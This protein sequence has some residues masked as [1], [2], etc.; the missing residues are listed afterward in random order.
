MKF[1]TTILIC[2]VYL[3]VIAQQ[4]AQFTQYN[5]VMLTVNPAYAG[6]RDMLNVTALHRQQWVGL[7]GAPIT[8]SV[9]LHTPLKYESLGIGLSVLNDRVGALNQSMISGDFSYSIRLDDSKNLRSSDGPRLSF[10]IKGSL[11]MLNAD[12]MALY[13]PDPNDVAF[14]QNYSNTIS[15]NVGM[16]VYF[17]SKQFFAGFSVPTIITPKYDPT[18]M[19]YARQRH[20]Y[21]TVGGYFIPNRMLKIRP[22]M[23]LKFTE[24][25]PLAID[26]SLA[27]IFYDKFWIAAN[28]R[29]Q[30]SAGVYAQYQLNKNFKVG[31]GFDIS[32]NALIKHNFGTHEIMVSYDLMKNNRGRIVSPRFF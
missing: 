1:L 10:G 24:G 4:E 8:Q 32:T 25:S 17:K 2:M 7:N 19:R 13:K 5:D 23:M 6:S 30:E 28:Y 31:Y 29:V 14:S 15:G 12:F 3:S 11:N 20:Y 18:N 26:G 16:G 27:F 9:T 22:T 21:A